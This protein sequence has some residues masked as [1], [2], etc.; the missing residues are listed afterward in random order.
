MSLRT[1][2]VVKLYVY[3]LETPTTAPVRGFAVVDTLGQMPRRHKGEAT[4]KPVNVTIETDGLKYWNLDDAD[5]GTTAAGVTLEPQTN[6]KNTLFNGDDI[7]PPEGGQV[8]FK[9]VK[10]DCWTTVL[11]DFEPRTTAIKWFSGDAEAGAFSAETEHELPAGQS[12]ALQL[13]TFGYAG[14]DDDHLQ[15]TWGDN[16]GLCLQAGGSAFFGRYNPQKN[17]WERLRDLPIPAEQFAGAE[18]VWV[19]VN[20][21]AGRVVLEIEQG[22]TKHQV[23]YGQAKA[24]GNPKAASASGIEMDSVWPAPGKVRVSGQGVPFTMRLHETQYPETGNFGRGYN[25]QGGSG[26]PQGYAYGHHPCPPTRVRGGSSPT[27]EDIATVGVTPGDGDARNYSCD[28]TRASSGGD[29]IMEG[30][31]SPFVQGV[32]VQ[33]AG[34]GPTAGGAMLCLTPAILRVSWEYGD[35]AL[36]PGTTMKATIRRDLLPYCHVYDADGQDIGAVGD[37]WKTFLNKYHQAYLVV[38]WMHEDGQQ[39]VELSS[40]ETTPSMRVFD[41]YVWSVSAELQGF[42]QNVGEIEFRDAIVRLQKP[43]GLIDSRFAP[44]D[45]LLATKGKRTLYGH[46]VVK[47]I[48]QQALGSEWADKLRVAFPPRHYD[49]LTYKMLTSPP[50]GTGF[51][52]PPPFGQSALDWIK[53]IAEIDFALFYFSI[54]PTDPSRGLVPNYGNYYSLIANARTVVLRDAGD[55]KAVSGTSW[56]Q[57]PSEDYN[58]VQVWG[59]VPGDDPSLYRD[60]MPA[61]PQISA[62]EWVRGSRI[63]EQDPAVTWERTLV[64]EGTHFF[65]P[66]IA[67]VV[68]RNMARL[69]KDEDL[70]RVTFKMRGQPFFTWGTKIVPT[71]DAPRSDPYLFTAGEVFRLMRS[72][73]DIDMQKLTW[74]TTLTCVPKGDAS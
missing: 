45:T 29:G 28:L 59:K 6:P 63:P 67:R 47:Y 50:M 1:T 69:L 25:Q 30:H 53:Q 8:T 16:Y 49:L 73:H 51:L 74:T 14:G 3:A 7:T 4:N 27:V 39:Y 34:S 13:Q 62:T 21:I 22:K 70:R 20:H 26:D 9:R 65:L 71:F 55:D 48:L 61:Y 72:S 24:V 57:N 10:G 19:R 33:Y 36:M 58:V 43:A 23:V 11:P 52:F 38:S 12:F 41:G 56:Q 60:M 64:K 2:P 17:S 37:A 42:G 44:A 15:V 40:G 32:T 54:D 18:P 31:V 5:S 66:N 46:E 35:P 68:A